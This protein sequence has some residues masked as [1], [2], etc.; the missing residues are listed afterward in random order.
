MDLNDIIPNKDS[1]WQVKKSILY[2]HKWVL[3]PIANIIDDR[4]FISI[5]QRC[6]NPTIKLIKHCEKLN[7]DFL[8]CDRN[9]IHEKHIYDENLEDIFETVLRCLENDKFFDEVN[10]GRI[11]FL[12]RIIQFIQEYDCMRIFSKVY[13]RLN[14]FHFQRTSYDFLGRRDYYFVKRQDIRD[15]F[16]SLEREVSIQLLLS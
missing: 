3:I 11:E 9:Q 4:L 7:I 10:L 8:F 2:Y 15:Y 1:N 14:K 13:S 12:N 5:D 16:E 6:I